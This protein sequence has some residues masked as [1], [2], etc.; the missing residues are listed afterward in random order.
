M[1]VLETSNLRSVIRADVS[2][3]ICWKSEMTIAV[4]FQ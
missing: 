4:T 3:C 1:F 2:M